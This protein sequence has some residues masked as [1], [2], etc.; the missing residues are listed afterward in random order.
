MFIFYAIEVLFLY[1]ITHLLICSSI[2]IDIFACT[3]IHIYY[4]TCM[5]LCTYVWKYFT[6]IIDILYL[7]SI[8][9]VRTCQERNKSS[10][11]KGKSINSFFNKILL[12]AKYS[13]FI[14]WYSAKE[15]FLL[16]CS[17]KQHDIAFCMSTKLACLD[18][19]SLQNLYTSLKYVGVASHIYL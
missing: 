18:H 8:V 2:Y 19:L 12:W 9:I 1:L 10:L 6:Y 13:L 14:M 17:L 16:A 11:L 5:Y 4:C 7:I 15:L 3:Y